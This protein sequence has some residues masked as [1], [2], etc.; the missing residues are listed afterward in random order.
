MSAKG[1][2]PKRPGG[3]EADAEK[4]ALRRW[5]HSAPLADA[6]NASLGDLL[7]LLAYADGIDSSEPFE[8]R[9]LGAISQLI[10]MVSYRD[11][12]IQLGVLHQ[13]HLMCEVFIAIGVRL[14]EAGPPL[15]WD[16]DGAEPK[17]PVLS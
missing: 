3:R 14:E 5:K 16:P 8:R 2:L 1:R 10:D 9:A 6:A 7:D 11:D 12:S 13:L 17:E 15:E 4:V